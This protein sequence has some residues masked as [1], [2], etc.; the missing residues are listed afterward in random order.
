MRDYF[1]I[2]CAITALLYF[3]IFIENRNTGQALVSRQFLHGK[4]IKEDLYICNLLKIQKNVFPKI[5]VFVIPK[6]KGYTNLP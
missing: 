4:C 6:S 2:R 3:N 1:Y 5:N